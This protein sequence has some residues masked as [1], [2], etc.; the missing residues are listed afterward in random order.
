[1]QLC[2][3]EGD[4]N[5]EN[6]KKFGKQIF[7]ELKDIDRNGLVID[8]IWHEIH[9][10]SSCDWKAAACIEGNYD[11]FRSITMGWVSLSP[12]KVSKIQRTSLYNAD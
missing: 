4:E 6:Q 3:F 7:D 10:S 8:G 11:Q 5:Y 9:V 1:M 2:L 12:G